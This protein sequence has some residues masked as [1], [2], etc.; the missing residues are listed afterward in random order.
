[1]DQLPTSQPGR[2]LS[3]LK[4]RKFYYYVI[5]VMVAVAT[6]VILR[7]VLKSTSNQQVKGPDKLKVENT[8]PAG[9]KYMIPPDGQLPK[10]FPKELVLAK[11]SK[12]L[13]AEDTTDGT[14]ANQKTVDLLAPLPVQETT[15]LYQKKI[16]ELGWK[17]K[18]S[19]AQGVLQIG[20]YAKD[21]LF[22]NVIISPKT[23]T[24]SQVSLNLR[25]AK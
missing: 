1:M 11:D 2:I 6:S 17:V 10:D 22:L 3:C 25:A 19:Y 12:I 15:D 14:G 4:S 5:F 18:A 8:L 23:A 16:P 7:N 9:Y 20:E 21:K 13:R 24:S